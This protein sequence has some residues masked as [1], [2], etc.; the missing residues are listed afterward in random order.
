M[1]ADMTRHIVQ[2][3][4]ATTWTFVCF[5]RIDPLGL[6][7]RPQ[8]IFQN[9]VS[10]FLSC[11]LK[12]LIPNFT[13][14]AAFFAGAVRR[15]E[16]KQPRIELFKRAP[17]I[18]ATH[19]RAQHCPL[20]LRTEQMS[21]PATD[22]ERALGKSARVVDSSHVD[23]PD[24]DRNAMFFETRQPAKLRNRNEL[25]INEQSV[26]ALSLGPACHVGVKSFSRF[27]QRRKH[28]DRAASRR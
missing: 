20:I 4:A 13:E 3:G 6:A 11:G 26:E 22:L 18:W 7:L 10:C 28:F 15:V 25:P 1:Q 9:R 23:H 2:A 16:R 21:C 17:A 12:F 5:D 8:F 24:N 27:Y 14:S 19:F